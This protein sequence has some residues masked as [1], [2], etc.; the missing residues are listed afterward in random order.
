MMKLDLM[1]QEKNK[2]WN[3]LSNIKIGKKTSKQK[4]V[5]NDITRFYNSREE[6]IN[7]FRDYG[8]MILDATHKSKQNETKEKGLK[9]LKP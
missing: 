2:F 1:K 5:I 3:K 4:G 8:K 6:T 9:K 7:S